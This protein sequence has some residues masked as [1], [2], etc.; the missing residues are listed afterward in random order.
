MK[1]ILILVMLLSTIAFWCFVV[2]EVRVFVC[3]AIGL[4]YGFKGE[5]YLSANENNKAIE[6]LNNAISFNP[7]LGFAYDYLGDAYQKKGLNSFAAYHFYKSGICYLETNKTSNA[8]NEFAKLTKLGL[9]DFKQES[10]KEI[11]TS[12]FA[13]PN[14]N[15]FSDRAKLGIASLLYAFIMWISITLFA[16]NYKPDDG[17][18]VL[19]IMFRIFRKIGFVK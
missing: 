1:K 6:S 17:K 13:N 5:N 15:N 8:E 3:N 10:F 16:R 11:K 18:Q 12:A 9:D 7:G 4:Y 14:F 19:E 2:Y